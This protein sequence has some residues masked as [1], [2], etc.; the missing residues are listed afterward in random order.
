MAEDSRPK[1]PQERAAELK[2]ADIA[3]HS[4]ERKAAFKARVGNALPKVAFFSMGY[5]LLSA[6][7]IRDA[8]NHP[9]SERAFGDWFYFIVLSSCLFGYI[10]AGRYRR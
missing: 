3:A 4:A 9:N 7:D 5:L 1:T 6:F 8:M 10:L 2:R